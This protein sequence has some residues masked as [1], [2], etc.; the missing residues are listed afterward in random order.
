M[1]AA[2]H[3]SRVTVRS[4]PGFS[5][6]ELFVVVGILV[7][8]FSIFVPYVLRI[9][10]TDRRSRCANNLREIFT[11]MT[12]YRKANHESYPSS[13]AD[14]VRGGYYVAFT[15]ASAVPAG[16]T[17]FAA[18]QP[19]TAPASQPAALP[20][21]SSP[22]TPSPAAPAIS[23]P[24]ATAPSV[25]VL[26]AATA[27]AGPMPTG[28]T[29]DGPRFNDVTAS[30]FLLVRAGLDP[31]LFVCPSGSES[32]DP[33]L[34]NGV[35][36]GPDRRS[37]FT[38]GE[39]LS[40][41]YASPFSAYR[42]TPDTPGFRLNDNVLPPDFALMADKN[43]GVTDGDNAAGPAWDA[44]RSALRV[45]N[46][47]NHGRA[48]QNVLYSTG[49]VEFKATPYSGYGPP[50]DPQTPYRDNIYTAYA[51]TPLPAL[52]PDPADPTRK[53]KPPVP[54]DLAG[55]GVFSKQAG[56]AWAYDSY[57]VPTADE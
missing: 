54:G 41:S 38:S 31:Q 20:S 1:I 7:I 23:A 53:P 12:A 40:Y 33:M 22:T 2:M 29:P 14:P 15:G 36:V 13:P 4:R 48:G 56:P 35:R 18:T 9:R 25:V 6:V 19:A 16:P 11:A 45:A 57:L 24:P 21:P 26:P 5:L 47:R 8:L 32:P 39:H 46:S 44:P 52:Q 10:E 34:S 28:P 43:P 37:N 30:L 50:T 17:D 51:A 27:P 42:L 55:K 3:R 49:V